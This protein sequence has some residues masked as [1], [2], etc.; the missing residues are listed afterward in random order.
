MVE[1]WRDDELEGLLIITS[2]H[3]NI[4]NKNHR[5]HT[6]NPVPT[7]LIGQRHEELAGDIHD[8]TDIAGVIRQVLG[9]AQ[10]EDISYG[11]N[12]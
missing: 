8:L 12:I 11:R 10:K 2:D 6:E 7:I 3:G 1:A 5:S 9:L 4:E